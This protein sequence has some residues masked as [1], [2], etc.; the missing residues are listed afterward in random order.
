MN[1]ARI[2]VAVSIISLAACSSTVPRGTSPVAAKASVAPADIVAGQRVYQ[3]YCAACHGGGDET[4]PVLDILHTLGRERVSVALS[5]DGLMA[6]PATMINENQRAH[7]IA[8]LTAPPA[9]L[10]QLA[11]ADRSTDP[12]GQNRE[13]FIDGIPYPARRIRA[14]RGADGRSRVSGACGELEPDFG[15]DFLSHGG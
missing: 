5:P 12:T 15:D 8:F 4:A 10:T 11:A 6:V 2:L 13:A 9:L 1:H 7:V 3:T 14:E